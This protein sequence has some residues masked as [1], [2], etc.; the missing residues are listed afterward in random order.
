MTTINPL[1]MSQVIQ[2]ESIY[3]Q[4]KEEKAQKCQSAFLKKFPRKNLGALTKE[5][6]S[7]GY[8]NNTFCYEVEF[9]TRPWAMIQGAT[10][11]KFGIYYGKRNGSQK[12]NWQFTKRAGNN[13]AIAWEN[14][15]QRLLDLIAEGAKKSP[16]FKVIDNNPLSQMF[17]AKVLSLYFPEKFINIC[18]DRHLLMLRDVFGFEH[19]LP[20]SEYQ[21]LLI[22]AKK[23][24]DMTFQWSNPKFMSFLYQYYINKKELYPDPKITVLPPT[25]ENYPEV[26]MEKIQ[27][28]WGRIGRLAEEF[29]FGWEL[30]RLRDNGLEEKIEDQR[31]KPQCGYDFLSHSTPSTHRYIEVKAVGKEKGNN[32]RFFLSEN[33]R[34]CSLVKE[35]FD[36]W[37]FYLVFFDGKGKPSHIKTVTAEEIYNVCRQTPVLLKMSFSLQDI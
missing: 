35:K 30:K 31:K 8:S 36:N 22:M 37:Y 18:S 4:G 1:D 15:H 2:F 13:L 27:E 24:N 20:I 23:T 3:D 14:T 16:D 19:D 11:A 34:V 33:E 21:H 9:A 10:A 7:S 29:A 5:T 6:Y 26:D 25:K 17:K 12:V 28:E 32:Y